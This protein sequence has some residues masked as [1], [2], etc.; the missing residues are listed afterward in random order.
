MPRT[1]QLIYVRALKLALIIDCI[2]QLQSTRQVSAS[3]FD[4]LEG[5]A[6]CQCCWCSPLPM[7]LV[8]ATVNHKHSMGPDV[9]P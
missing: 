9:P 8:L 3:Q 7:L 2:R 1:Y 5:L 6:L 4:G